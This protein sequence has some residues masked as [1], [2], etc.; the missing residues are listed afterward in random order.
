M[1]KKEIILKKKN[2]MKNKTKYLILKFYFMPTYLTYNLKFMYKE[3]I[4]CLSQ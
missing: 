3:I 1:W 4:W 2:K